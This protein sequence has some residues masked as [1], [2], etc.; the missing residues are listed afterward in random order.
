MLDYKRCGSAAIASRPVFALALTLAV[1][2]A[3]EAQQT[4]IESQ[5]YR[6]HSDLDPAATRDY[7]R[8]LDAMYREY[9]KRLAEFE[10]KNHAK[11]EV[12]LF[13]KQSDYRRFTG[14]K[15]PHSSGIFIPSLRALAGY[16]ESQ[17]RGGLRQTL[18]HEAFHQFAW[19]AISTNLPIWLDEGLA[20]V[21]EEGVWTGNQFLIGQVPPARIRDLKADMQ[22][23]RFI[24][25]KTFLGL[26]REQFQ[27]RM[28]DPAVGRSMYNQAWAMTHFL[29]F[30][31]DERGRPRYRARLMN[32]LRDMHAGR[33]PQESFVS[34]FSSNFTGFEQRF[35]EWIATLQ[36]TPLGVYSDR[37]SKLA[38][39]VRL[40]KE[41]G[42]SFDSP[43]ALR[44]HLSRG[45]F[46]LTQQRDGQTY[47]L[48]ENALT[49]LCDLSNKPWPPDRLRFEQRRGPLP[50]IVLRSPES[51]TIRVRFYRLGNTIDHDIVFE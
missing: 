46:Y 7:A 23:G 2:T 10:V 25:F 1:A 36:P 50:D 40:F 35:R 20:Q 18:Q 39:L 14:N 29:V 43:D 17:G 51:A 11:F 5:H 45:T 38:D 3:A 32:W 22:A 26:S 42:R 33:D 21:F 6:I 27:A 44:Q 9:Q 41:E 12:Y 37:M 48:E 4:T 31:T 15:L 28:R 16:E 24:D 34:N 8:R 47:T 49:Y 19:Q 30:A 13:R